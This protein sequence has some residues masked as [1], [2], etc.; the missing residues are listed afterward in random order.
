MAKEHV[1]NAFMSEKNILFKN[2]NEQVE[3]D[4]NEQ[5]KENRYYY[6]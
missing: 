1:R 6:L 5:T 2:K 3:G 4:K